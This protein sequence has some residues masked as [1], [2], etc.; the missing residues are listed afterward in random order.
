MTEGD[1]NGWDQLLLSQKH[2]Q[3]NHLS[4]LL[5]DESHLDFL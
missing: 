1:L 3:C 4:Y 5:A 2:L